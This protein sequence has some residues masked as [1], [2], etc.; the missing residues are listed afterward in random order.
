[1][2][3]RYASHPEDFR[4]YT[5]EKTRREFLI[6]AVMVAGEITLV[7]SHVDRIIAGG[8]VP[9]K[10]LALQTGRETGLHNYDWV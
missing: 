3:I 9:V 10:P 4:T 5:T 1:M 8:I 6:P 2:E 7:S